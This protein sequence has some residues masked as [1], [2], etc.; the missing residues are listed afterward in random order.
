[1]RKEDRKLGL[2]YR[3]REEDDQKKVVRPVMFKDGGGQDELWFTDEHISV[4]TELVIK[5]WPVVSFVVMEVIWIWKEEFQ[6]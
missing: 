2:R 4:Q 1:M 3:M 6:Q 5:G